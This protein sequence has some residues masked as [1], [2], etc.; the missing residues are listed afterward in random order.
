MQEVVVTAKPIFAMWFILAGH[1]HAVESSRFE[2]L[3]TCEKALDTE[4][5]SGWGFSGKRATHPAEV[6]SAYCDRASA[7]P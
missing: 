2:D 6:I 4:S 5:S 7:E 1:P 3:A